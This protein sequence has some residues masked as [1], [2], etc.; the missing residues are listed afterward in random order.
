[1]I[2][3]GRAQ[4]FA[5][6]RRYLPRLLVAAFVEWIGTG[7]F[8]AASAIYFVQV[9]GL[10]ESS[11]GLGM[12]V[13]GVVAML[14]VVPL[15]TLAD[16]W[17]ARRT[18]VVVS[19][20]RGAAVAGYLV[21][22]GWWSFLAVTTAVVIGEQAAH[23]LTQALVGE[24]T[25][26]DLRA[27]VMAAH[28]TALNVGISVGGLLA[29]IPL[30]V[31]TS[32]AFR[33]TFGCVAA[34]FVTTGL[35][36]KLLPDVTVTTRPAVRRF[37][38]LRD[39]RLLALTAY[40]GVASLW[41]PMLN[42]AFPLWLTGHTNAPPALVGVLYAVNTTAC[43]LLQLPMSR[44]ATTPRQA[45][46]SYSVSGVLLAL[47]CVGF[48]LA[49]ALH[50]TPTMVLLAGA[51]L[52]LTFGELCQV[53]GAWTLS[54]ALAPPDRRAEYLAAFSLGRT[55]SGKLYGPVL[56]TGVVLAL[57]TSGWFLLG[58][59]LAITAAL[60]LVASRLMTTS[61]VPQPTTT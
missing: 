11:V 52:L 37:D 8:I 56:M 17:G 48:A 25:T 1:M 54:Y 9:V 32:A 47:S 42:I 15:G 10:P 60:P 6:A 38:A 24:R 59:L 20:W 45:L 50:G 5:R 31:G 40:D 36:V 19:L 46:N 18:L 3:G 35:L 22:D 21:V 7:L 34:I 16:R 39:R 4:R 44:F 23:P 29:A 14:A 53:N 30:T 57:G 33:W 49:P 51:I 27:R 58:A 13:S 55:A 12:L 28:R 61:L 43:V 2:S 41:L 26:P